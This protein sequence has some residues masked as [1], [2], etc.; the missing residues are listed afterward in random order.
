[1]KKFKLTK[2]HLKLL[3]RFEVSWQDCE[4]GAPEID[5]KRPYGNSDV[6]ND[7]HEIL[8]GETICCVNS[9]RDELTEDEKEKYSKLH[10]EMETALQIILSTLSFKLGNYECEEYSNDWKLVKIV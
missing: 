6:L 3:K 8:T 2:N 7:I 5:P 9:K 10:K 4:F 1:M